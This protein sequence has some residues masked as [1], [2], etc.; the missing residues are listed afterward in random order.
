M[1][2]DVDV[3]DVDVVVEVDEVVA[4]ELSQLPTRLKSMPP[5]GDSSLPL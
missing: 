4:S 3:V 5:P 1:V 2:D